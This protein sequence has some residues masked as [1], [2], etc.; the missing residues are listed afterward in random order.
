MHHYHT[1]AALYFNVTWC[2]TAYIIYQISPNKTWEGFFGAMLFT[3]AFAY[4]SSGY[5]AQ[6]NWFTC[7]V[8]G[9]TLSPVND[10]SC[11]PD[12]IFQV[13]LPYMLGLAHLPVTIV[14]SIH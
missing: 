8:E 3:I 6:F 5:L 14:Y 2:D 13:I 7:P 12:L 10:L 9:L 1:A 11:T 4:F